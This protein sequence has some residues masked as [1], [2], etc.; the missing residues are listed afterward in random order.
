MLFKKTTLSEYPTEVSSHGLNS[1]TSWSVTLK[2]NKCK[3]KTTKNMA[4]VSLR[5]LNILRQKEFT[6]II[7]W[8]ESCSFFIYNYYILHYT[9]ATIQYITQLQTDVQCN[10][11]FTKT[12]SQ[13]NSWDKEFLKVP[14]VMHAKDTNIVD[15]KESLTKYFNH[16]N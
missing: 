9:C 14:H 3:L 5:V 16:F 6:D 10:P 12:N 4:F 8:I 7:I 1:H 11:H 2:E 13:L 15:S